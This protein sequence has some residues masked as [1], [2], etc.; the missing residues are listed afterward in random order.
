M[1]EQHVHAGQLHESEAVFNVVVPSG[2][3]AAEVVDPGEQPLHSPTPAVT[4]Q[5]APALYFAS[6]VPVW[7]NQFDRVLLGES[8]VEF[9][10][11]VS[12][13]AAEPR[14]EFVEEVPPKNILQKTNSDIAGCEQKIAVIPQV[15]ACYCCLYTPDLPVQAVVKDRSD[16]C[17]LKDAVAVL[18][19][20]ESQQKVLSCNKRARDTGL[21]VGMTK[22]Q[23]ETREITL[24]KRSIHQEA[25]IHSAIMD[26]GFSISPLLE[27][28]CPG[29]IIIA[30]TGAQRL[31]GS[32]MDIG[33]LL[34]A[35]AADCGIK[36]HIAFASNPDTALYA[37]RGFSDI[38]VIEPG[39]EAVRMASLPIKVLQLEE[40]T[41]AALDIWGIRNFH[42][43]STLPVL[44]LVQ[45]LGQRGVYIQ[46]RAQGR[47]NRKLIPAEPN[48]SFQESIELDHGLELLE[49]M[50]FLINRLLQQLFSR[51]KIRSLAT[52][53]IQISLELE[54]YPDQQSKP[55]G[56][57]VA[58]V[59]LFQRTIKLPV[60]TQD[61]SIL[62]KLLELQL[63]EHPPSA[64]VK[65]LMIEAY[66]AAIRFMQSGLLGPRGPEPAKLEVAIQRL[67]CVVGEQDESG[68]HR[69]GVPRFKDSHKVDSHEVLPRPW[70]VKYKKGRARC[71]SNVSLR[72]FRPPL[73]ATIELKDNV[74]SAIL[75]KGRRRTVSRASGPWYKN[76]GWWEKAEEWNRSEWDIQVKLHGCYGFYRIFHDHQ[77]EQWFVE[78]TYD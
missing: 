72:T 71:A 34:V 37:A 57:V 5:F 58:P 30:I 40:E 54:H 38:T 20:P 66:P 61:A 64:P 67:R 76:G 11:I 42:S 3:E 39:Q 62:L 1:P 49:P 25:A 18:D 28:T 77:S 43:L 45:R 16:L 78:G 15:I 68:S 19:G 9:V 60:P 7:R 63:A 55:E 23:A 59:A 6:V 50:M 32:P 22:K 75:F 21:Q 52:D 27:S 8:G 56:T 48:A 29:T 26:C 74:P 10:R 70:E 73:R 14:W 46:Q 47:V 24:T 2:D 13:V 31:L 44:P 51:L 4:A 36:V 33:E 53:Q 35:R 69:V 12:F 65:K 17:Y 41:E